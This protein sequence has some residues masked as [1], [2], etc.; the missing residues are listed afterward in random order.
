MKCTGCGAQL[1][2]YEKK[3]PYCGTWREELSTKKINNPIDEPQKNTSN[4]KGLSKNKKTTPSK[5]DYWFIG[6]IATVIFFVLICIISLM[7][8]CC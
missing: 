4:I 6:I 7:V 2:P 5:E 8:Q 3:C 1:A